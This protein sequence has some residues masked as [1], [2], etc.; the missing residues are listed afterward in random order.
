MENNLYTLLLRAKENDERAVAELLG[1][2]EPKIKKLSATLPPWE[3][4]DLE[5]ELRIQI[6]HSIEKFN[7]SYCVKEQ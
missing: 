2:F 7:L 1:R 5:Q 3:R 4:E 6:I